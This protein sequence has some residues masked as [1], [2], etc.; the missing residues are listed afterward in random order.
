MRREPVKTF[1]QNNRATIICPACNTAKSVSVAAF[2]HK[3]HVIRAKCVCGEVFPILL[4]FR[5]H[6][7]KKVKLSGKYEVKHQQD[8]AKGAMHI[9]D[10][11]ESGLRFTVAGVNLLQP[12][13]LLALDFQLD[14]RKQSRIQ[15]LATVRSVQGNAIGCE[16]IANEPIERS[17]AFYLRC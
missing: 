4:D 10:L 16:F 8:K 5:N 9:T 12:G 17:L 11:S 2:R 7:R 13:Y 3:Q 15:K 6:Y 14:D 1:V